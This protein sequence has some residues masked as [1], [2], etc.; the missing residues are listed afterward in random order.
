MHKI[1]EKQ[2]EKLKRV[3][4]PAEL[5]QALYDPLL[6]VTVG[7]G[8][9]PSSQQCDVLEKY[10][11]ILLAKGALVN[12]YFKTHKVLTPALAELF[13]S[14][15]ELV[16]YTKKRGISWMAGKGVGKNATM[17]WIQ[18]HFLTYHSPC[19][20]PC[21]MPSE[22]QLQTITWKEF[23]EWL[24]RTNKDGSYCCL[25]KDWFEIGSEFIYARDPITGQR[26]SNCFMFQKTVI[27]DSD[28]KARTLDGVHSPNL[29]VNLDE[30]SN[31]HLAVFNSLINTLTEA[32]NFAII[33]FNPTE[34]H[35]YAYDTHFKEISEQWITIQSDSEES[36]L[37]TKEHIEAL[38]LEYKD[39]PDDYRI[40]VKGLPAKHGRNSYIPKQALL[41]AQG[42]KFD[43]SIYGT[44]LGIDPSLGG[45]DP[46]VGCIRKGPNV[47]DFITF[48]NSN[49]TRLTQQIINEATEL[50]ADA[51][52]IEVDGLGRGIY[53][54]L[55]A[56]CSSCEV[57]PVMINGGAIEEELYYS[58]KEEL[59]AKAQKLIVDHLVGFPNDWEFIEE[60]SAFE[61]DSREHSRT[62]QGFKI[63]GGNKFM[64]DKIGRSANKAHAY[65]VT[66]DLE[67]N[68]FM[69]QVNKSSHD[70]FMERWEQQ[71]ANA[72]KNTDPYG[73]MGG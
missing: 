5:Y 34:N 28:G 41:E 72:P 37:V 32:N 12:G 52:F 30:G 62:R 60:M 55:C 27:I 20:I 40:Y 36:E 23:D 65:L 49:I 9:I 58:K 43:D 2:I 69:K 48:D 67:D 10:Y 57:Y 44:V 53:D 73:W 19:K 63:K 46:A 8:A 51:I 31:I 21:V 35:G 1:S 45:S 39:R 11:K 16:A 7:M 24:K 47:V 66:L 3:K 14:F 29:Y 54:L 26:K 38:K 15:D 50:E 33:T 68:M 56:H 6:W 17:A 25:V 64:K 22:K 18:S 59:L 71:R 13:E 4:D 61:K 42:I 70:K